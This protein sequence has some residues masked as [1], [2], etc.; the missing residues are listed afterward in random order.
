MP[1]R[2]HSK[3]ASSVLFLTVGF[4]LL[5]NLLLGFLLFNQSSRAMTSL[6]Q[7]RMLDISNTAAA[8]LDGDTLRTVSPAD[9]GT[10][11]YEQIMKTLTYFQDS[12]DL[13]YIYC[14]RDMG[15]GTFT[16]GLD[17]TVEDPGEFGSPI[18]RTDA[19][20]RAAQGTPAAD[21][22]FYKDAWGTFYS[23]YSPVFD[24]HGKVAGIVAVDFS[25][26]WYE[27][28]LQTLTRTIVIVAVLSQ[29]IGGGI[30][31]VIVSRNTRRIKT[32][33]GQ[34]NDLADNLMHEMSTGP[35]A[36][37]DALG[38]ETANAVGR[39]GDLDALSEKILLLQDDLRHQASRVRRH[40]YHDGLTGIRN[41]VAYLDAVMNLETV[42]EEGKA[43]FSVVVLDMNG[44]KAIND[45]Y[46]HE[47]GDSALKDMAK[48]LMETFGADHAYRIGG[49][50][51]VILLDTSKE[52]D[53]R[54]MLAQ[55]DDA[56][57]V[58]N[59]QE[60]P[61][62]LPLSLS[63][64]YSIY[65]PDEEYADVFRRADEAMYANKQAHY[66]KT[67]TNR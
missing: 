51:F 14:I 24:S 7:S 39:D 41:R 59:Q 50:E 18:V 35:D 13:K 58:A 1:N 47:A 67:G 26:Q 62:V 38:S 60:R 61:Y 3:H 22:E 28:Q 48:V 16:F 63:R 9:K 42:V 10:P 19:L 30:V 44:L 33:S 36:A 31:Y 65:R 54:R 6:M 25:A 66:Q 45:T 52:E 23:A 56:L 46:G 2:A 11:G 34:L 49:D 64:G 8:M 20:A 55:L 37:S 40:A 27:E 32:V 15:D 29:L 4:L 5:V 17:P 21:E 43:A 53:V 12:I 57:A